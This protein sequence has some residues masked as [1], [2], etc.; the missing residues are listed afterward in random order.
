MDS[1]SAQEAEAPAGEM[2][3][4]STHADWQSW[5]LFCPSSP[6]LLS[7]PVRGSAVAEFSVMLTQG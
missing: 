2:T 5:I 3:G 6:A 4:H 1:I 7:F